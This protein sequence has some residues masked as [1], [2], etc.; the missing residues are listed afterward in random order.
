VGLTLGVSGRDRATV[1]STWR[2][3]RNARSRSAARRG[4]TPVVW[5]E[6]FH[7]LASSAALASL[8]PPTRTEWRGF[9][10]PPR[11]RPCGPRVDHSWLSPTRR[12]TGCDARAVALAAQRT[13][14]ASGHVAHADG[15]GRW[16]ARHGRSV[17]ARSP[18]VAASSR[19]QPAPRG[20]ASGCSRRA[21]EHGSFHNPSGSLCV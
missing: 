5:V 3:A 2:L 8:V 14:D 20:L 17:V 6:P 9:H 4:H 13:T 7:D 21:S 12:G 11:T 10:S 15:D 1:G 19:H 16:A 18:H